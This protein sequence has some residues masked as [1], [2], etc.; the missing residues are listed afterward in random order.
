MTRPPPPTSLPSGPSAA[1]LAAEDEELNDVVSRE[2]RRTRVA[3]PKALPEHGERVKGTERRWENLRLAGNGPMYIQPP[4]ESN[5]A[6]GGGGN[7]GSSKRRK[8]KGKAQGAG[9]A[10]KTEISSPSV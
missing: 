5:Q 8:G 1:E 2:E 6:G 9:S 10:G 3:P 4:T 7:S